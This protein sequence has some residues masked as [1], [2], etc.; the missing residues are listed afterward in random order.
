MSWILTVLIFVLLAAVAFNVWAMLRSASGD[1]CRKCGR[2]TEWSDRRGPICPSC[3]VHDKDDK[4]GG[5]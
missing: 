4:G 3:R 5:L 1:L 2:I